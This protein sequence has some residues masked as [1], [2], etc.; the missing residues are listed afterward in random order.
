MSIHSTAIV[1][2]KA[3]LGKDNEIGPYA[4]IEDGVRIGSHNKIGAATYICTGTEIGD[5]NEIHMHAVIGNK[6]QDLAYD[7]VPTKTII[8]NKNIIP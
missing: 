3:V 5:E 1:G 7:G 8:G 6:P 4:V 2:K